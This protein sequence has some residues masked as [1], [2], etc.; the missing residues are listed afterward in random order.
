M[1]ARVQ[2]IRVTL[3]DRYAP[4]GAILLSKRV[5]DGI[6]DNSG[7]VTPIRYHFI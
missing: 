4:I 1:S 3:D 2:Y 5:A 6:R 7:M